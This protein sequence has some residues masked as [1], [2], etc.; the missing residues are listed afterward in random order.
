MGNLTST[1]NTVTVAFKALTEG[2]VYGIRCSVYILPCY[3]VSDDLDSKRRFS[4]GAKCLLDEG[5][6]HVWVQLNTHEKK[7]DMG[8]I[9]FKPTTNVHNSKEVPL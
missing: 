7:F 5:L 8:H 2:L 4:H 1:S 9:Y 6:I 3:P